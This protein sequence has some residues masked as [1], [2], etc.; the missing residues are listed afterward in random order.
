MS[1][2][3]RKHGWPQLASVI[4]A[5]LGLVP[6][7]MSVSSPSVVAQ[8]IVDTSPRFASDTASAMHRPNVGAPIGGGYAVGGFPYGYTVRLAGQNPN[9]P[10]SAYGTPR[11]YGAHDHGF[12]HVRH[13][14]QARYNQFGRNHWVVNPIVPCPPICG[15]PMCGPY[16]PNCYP[17]P[18]GYGN[19][20]PYYFPTCYRPPVY[21]GIPWGWNPWFGSGFSGAWGNGGFAQGNGFAVMQGQGFFAGQGMMAGPG[22]GGL[23]PDAWSA[24]L[25][26]RPEASALAPVEIPF[27]P[28]VVA[29]RLIQRRA[30]DVMAQHRAVAEL[31][32]AEIRAR[33]QTVISGVDPLGRATVQETNETAVS[34]DGRVYSATRGTKSAEK[35]KPK[36]AVERSAAESLA[37]RRAAQA[38]AERQRLLDTLRQK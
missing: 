29:D 32:A 2:C 9:Y 18:Y 11:Q 37:A 14:D 31:E 1:F 38:E 25:L 12:A 6:A 20:Y 35:N 13:P 28:G 15:P 10:F 26:A 34:K 17:Y 7:L 4:V 16:R 5:L 22:F 8:R 36:S 21:C 19:C 3:C 27:A 33:Q 24:A 30:A 23:E